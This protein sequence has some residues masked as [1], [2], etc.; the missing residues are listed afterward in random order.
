MKLKR[1]NMDRSISVVLENVFIMAY[2]E[3]ASQG[4]DYENYNWIL[5]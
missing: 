3:R 5:S 4:T 1:N 2:E